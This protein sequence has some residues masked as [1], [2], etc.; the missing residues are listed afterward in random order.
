MKDPLISALIAVGKI[1]GKSVNAATATAGLPLEDGALTPALLIRAANRVGFKAELAE[2]ELKE[3]R[4][5]LLPVVLITEDESAVV[6]V[7]REGKKHCEWI[8]A[9]GG[10]ESGTLADLA[11]IYAGYAILIRE[12]YKFEE[13]ATFESVPRAKSWFWGTLWRFRSFY[14][15]VAIASLV[16][17]LFALTSSLFIMNVY[18]RVVPNQAFETLYVLA[19]GAGVVFAFDFVL[20]TLRSFFVD[21][22]GQRAD[23]LLGSALFE[24][25]LTLKFSAKPKSA[26]AFAS[27][28]RAYESLR[29]FFTSATI[30]ALVDLPFV[31]LFAGVVYLLGGIVAAPLIIGLGFALFVGLI[32]QLPLARAVQK[33]YQASNQRHALVVESISGLETV[34]GLGAESHLQKKM[35][36]CIRE[37]SDSEV[38]SKGIS[39]LS[40][41]LTMITQQLV[42]VGIVIL[43]VYQ[44]AAGNM[45]MGGL[46]ACVI[47]GGRGMA[48]L[49]QVAGLFT[50]LQQSL[51]ALKGLNQIMR[52]PRERTDQS[53]FV[54]LES[55]FKPEIKCEG[56]SFTYPG[57]ETPVLKDFNLSIKPGE[58]VVLL[59]RV[60]SGK[61]TLM[62]LAAGL[63]EPNEGTVVSSGLDLRQ[64]DPAEYRRHLGYVPQQVNLFYG[65][66]ADN[67]R[68]GI[69][70]AED[71][72]V[73]EAVE[74]AGVNH[75]A[76]TN[77]NGLSMPV[78]EGG[79]LLSGGQR[80]AVALAR[81]L[82][83]KPS[84]LL[85]DEPTSAMDMSSEAEIVAHLKKYLDDSGATLVLSTHKPALFS[86]ATRIVLIKDGAVAAD[87]PAEEILAKLLPTKPTTK[88]ARK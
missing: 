55:A 4:P 8:T 32:L 11:K 51:A 25:I 68:L 61:T 42:S 46:I 24:Q 73:L 69:P 16:I 53:A 1:H 38:Q 5:G 36:D 83:P 10:S 84:F 18:D 79:E 81:A 13:R 71:E 50:K 34:K 14:V 40:T 59:G 76:S 78:G 48:P 33:G 41:H 43:G 26:G 75:F 58:R 45:T 20:R 52:L 67:L 9:D 47:L 66:L 49:A 65:T 28:A 87:G 22:A 54:K 27:Q 7:K 2:R 35:E 80:Q 6:L 56:L 12:E 60:G 21:R 86:L 82:V 64:F 44:L 74:L 63:L 3:I 30:V 77:P 19:I 23:I 88:N 37:S 39:Q 62:K 31:F 17:N 29:E 57:S 70:W 15:R 72:A 85:L